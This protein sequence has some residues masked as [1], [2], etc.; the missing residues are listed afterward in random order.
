MKIRF[1]RA[2]VVTSCA[3]ASLPA[4]AEL[5]LYGG[6]GFHGQSLSVTRNMGD[7]ERAGFNDRASSAIVYREHWEVCEHARFE[8]R[9]VVL[10][11]GRYP[12]LSAMGLDNRVSSVRMVPKHASA[13]PQAHYAPPAYPVYDSRPR[14]DEHLHEAQVV[15]VRAIYGQP[16][17]RCWV[18][19]EQ[20]ADTSS[21][22]GGAVVGAIIGGVL[23]H[24]VGGGRGKDV[25]T[26]AGAAGGAVLGA[27]IARDANGNP[28]TTRDV[29]RCGAVPGSAK[30]EYWDVTYVFKGIEHHMQTAAPPGRTITVNARGEPRMS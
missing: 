7:L 12:N 20:V 17:Q 21:V 16:Q 25:A 10:R 23:G 4:A 22:A 2:L 8:G 6:E 29:K 28:I 18:D 26:A 1:A 30:V 11:P 19:R 27:N 14:R 24:Q 5:V 9:C 3:L 13:P 15:S